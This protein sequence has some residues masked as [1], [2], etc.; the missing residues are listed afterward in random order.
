MEIYKNIVDLI[1]PSFEK[2]QESRFKNFFKEYE[3]RHFEDK[4]LK[5]NGYK[6]YTGEDK[7]TT[8]LIKNIPKNMTKNQ[9]KMILEKIANINYIYVP[10]FMLTRYNLRCAF[11][12]VVNPKSIIDIYLK[13][14]KINFKYDNPN[15]KIEISYSNIQGRKELI[16][17]FREERNLFKKQ[18]NTFF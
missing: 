11:V 16:E 4:I 13:L 5:L 12:N 8:I 9:L 10:L 17:N 6:I 15:T 2:P 1:F 7:R 18:V 3:K 14:R